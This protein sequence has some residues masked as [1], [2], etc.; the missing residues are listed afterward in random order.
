MPRAAWRSVVRPI[1]RT[2]L[3]PRP[4]DRIARARSSRCQGPRH[5]RSL[6]W[7]LH[8]GRLVHRRQMRRCSSRLHTTGRDR[9]RRD[10]RHRPMP[11]ALVRHSRTNRGA[12]A[13]AVRPL[14]PAAFTPSEPY[15]PVPLW[16][17]FRGTVTPHTGVK[18]EPVAHA[19]ARFAPLGRVDLVTRKLRARGRDVGPGSARFRAHGEASEDVGDRDS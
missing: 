1:R 7:S 12:S 3:T 9:S 14:R 19:L 11:S 10:G 2:G 13:P 15:S 5:N 4:L 8:Q 18:V 6:E 17:T 16:T